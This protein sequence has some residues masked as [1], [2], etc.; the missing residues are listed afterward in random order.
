MTGK[1]RRLA[2]RLCIDEPL[3]DIVSAAKLIH[4]RTIWVARR[5][6]GRNDRKVI[7][8]YLL[9]ESAPSLHLGAGNHELDGWLNSSLY[10]VSSKSIHIDATR[11]FP[12]AD[13]MFRYAFSNHMI[14]HLSYA[15]GERMLRECF[16]VL[17]PGGVLRV[18]T[19]DFA[20]LLRIYANPADPLIDRYIDWQLDWIN[21]E[22][23][24]AAPTK[25]AIFVCNNFV[26]DWGHLFI[27]DRAILLHAMA[28][29]GFVDIVDCASNESMHVKL[30]G[31]EH[32][33]RAPDGFVRLETMTLEGRKPLTAGQK[34]GWRM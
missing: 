18:S 3:R 2:E 6:F 32:E 4:R 27:Y 5:G 14:E 25:A 7:D 21:R 13:D 15:A 20:F 9:N 31:I 10:P 8:A 16:R 28:E 29:A 1:L 23:P 19:P 26:R 11:P 30:C 33:E 12:F 17:E 22:D 24:R 34:N